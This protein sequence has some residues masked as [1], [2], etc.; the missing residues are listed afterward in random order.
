MQLK[1]LLSWLQVLGV[2]L[3]AASAGGAAPAAGGDTLAFHKSQDTMDADVRDFDLI[4]LLKR[5]AQETGWHVYVEPVAGFKASARFV[6]LPTSQAL[7]RLLGDM[8]FA[9]AP[10]TNEAPCLY[11]FEQ[12]RNQATQR[13]SAAPT[14]A[15]RVPRELVIRARDGVDVEALA[16]S[17]GAKITGRIPELNAYRLEFEDEEALEKARS[18]LA[19]NPGIAS[20]QD[21]FFVDA[22]ETPQSLTG[23]MAADNKLKL[24]PPKSDACKVVV[25]FVD[26]VLQPLSANLEPFIKERLSVT[27]QSQADPNQPTHATAMVNAYFQA[28]QSS[29]RTSSSVPIISVDVFGGGAAANTFSVAQGMILAANRGATVINASLGGYGDSPLLRDTV[30]QLTTQ[31]IP[32]FAAVGNDA[33]K[34]AFFPAAY[35]EVVSVTAIERGQVAPYANIGTKPDVATPGAVLFNYNGLTYGARGTSVSSAAATGVAA[36]LADANCAP[37]TAVIPAIEKNLPVP[38]SGK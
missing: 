33:S 30:K 38:D 29:G 16:K 5:I 32:V 9:I 10:Q 15:R 7:R 23:M 31:N 2:G 22:P 6:G 17:L 4:P 25:G 19:A 36:G 18:L 8:N 37:W 13:V 35:P 14:L 3:W 11:V 26:T 12:S 28:L 24:D 1:K 27:G 34:N 21:N 20:V